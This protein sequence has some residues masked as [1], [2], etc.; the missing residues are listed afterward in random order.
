MLRRG[1]AVVTTLA[2]PIVGRGTEL[3]LL[4]RM[5]DEACGG[6]SRFVVVAGEPGIGKTSLLGE[7]TSRAQDRDCLVLEGRAAEFELELPFGLVVDA[8]DAYLESLDPRTYDRLAADGL[9]ELASVF[10]S[11][12]SLGDGGSHPS[13]PAERFR[14]HH[15]VREL[16]ERLAAR[17]PV[18]LTLDD[19]HWSDGASLELIGHLVRR[20]PEA[21]VMVAVAYR[22]GQARPALAAAI[23]GAVRD[24]EIERIE[25]GPLEPEAAGRLVPAERAAERDRLLRD[26][27]GNPFYLLQLAR[28]GTGDGDGGA[29]ATRDGEGVP[30]AVA[31]AIA[32][33]LAAL[34][35][36][37]RQFAQAAAV[38]GDPFELDLAVAA[39]DQPEADTLPALDELIARDVVRAADVPRRFRFRHPLVRGAIYESSPMGFRLLAHERIAAA[40]AER[41]A[42]ASTRAN[43]VEESARHGDVAAVAVLRDAGLEAAGRAPTSAA[44]WFSAA[45][46]IL[47]ESAAPGERSLLLAAQ[48]RAQAATGQLEDSRAALVEAIGLCEG[49]PPAQRVELISACAGFEQLLGRHG[50]AHRRLEAALVDLDTPGSPEAVSLMIDLAWDACLD[51]RYDE[52]L[53]WGSRA[54]ESARPL[55]DA[56]L[57]AAAA[58]I[59]ALAAACGGARSDGDSF[60]AEAVSILDGL[61]D[62]VLAVRPHA[63]QWL[64]GADFYLD[65]YE[66]GIEHGKRG[67]TVAR[68]GGNGELLPGIAQALGGL[69]IRTGRLTEAIEFLDDSVDAARLTDNAAA[70]CWALGNRCSAAVMQGDVPTAVALGEETLAATAQLEDNFVRARAGAPVGAALLLA[71]QPER[72]IDALLEAAG[73]EDMPLVPAAWRVVSLDVLTRS[74]LAADRAEDAE[75]AAT[76]AEAIA[77]DFGTPFALALAERARAAVA[78]AAGDAA[79]AAERALASVEHADEAG[80]AID[81][82][83]A[84]TLAG[85][86]LALAGDAE[87]ATAELEQAAT[88]LDSCGA[89]RYRD[90]AERELRKLGRPVHRRTRRGRSDAAGLESLTG[91]ELEI[92]RLV[93]ARRTN[94]EIAAELFLS[95]KTVETHM[96]NIFRKLGAASRVEVARIIEQ[97]QAG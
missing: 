50:E 43:H 57:T 72:A 67:T 63:F 23:E 77:T 12:R 17:Q 48:A 47:P 51:A 91:R 33:E 13:G 80:A 94:P 27:G 45:L 61:P 96:R 8:F 65:H 35:D 93:V 85:R 15:A 90:E 62:E 78:I 89:Q 97:A 19:V 55:G 21:A 46:R 71:G 3:E 37:V 10:P 92:A 64:C 38:S 36:P 7:L 26:S 34:P 28:S 69:L 20:R 5:L 68:A 53:A 39:A 88:A 22:A 9:D 4:E 42:P 66:A 52:M 70:L 16:I 2:P 25:L 86:S 74:Y 30:A 58:A 87:R 95:I 75:R 56:P 6:S 59:C 79:A 84:R 76:R 81:A 44:R 41:G 18:L 83:L 11:L 1:F 60:R 82:A 40:L 49:A 29:G 54:L 32:G 31:T 73:G 24:G 14:A